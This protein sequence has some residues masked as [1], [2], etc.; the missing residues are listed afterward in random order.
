MTTDVSHLPY[1]PCVGIML[2]NRENKVFTAKR[3]D[4]RAEAWQMPQG[5]IDE[6]E[7]PRAA[8][9]RELEEETGIRPDRVEIIAESK[10][11]IPYDLPVELVPQLWKGRY[12]G[13]TQKWF[14]L[15]FLGDD[16]EI[17]LDT[18]TPEFLDWKWVTMHDLPAFIVPFKRELYE[19]IVA[20]FGYLVK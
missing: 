19:R 9:I 2:L 12:R 6:G 4:M 16:S 8:A 10:D 18:E 3:I 7:N 13:Q 17:N 11:W 14:V 1:R 5:G 20:E 15:R